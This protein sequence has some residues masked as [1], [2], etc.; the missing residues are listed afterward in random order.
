[1]PHTVFVRGIVV[2]VVGTGDLSVGRSHFVLA[3]TLSTIVAIFVQH[4]SVVAGAQIRANCILAL[5]LT[6]AVVDCALVDVGEEDGG[7]ST[8]LYG[9]VRGELNPQ[10]IRFGRYHVGQ[11]RS[12]EQSMALQILIGDLRVDGQRVVVTFGLE[13]VASLQV[14]V[15]EIED[16]LVLG[17]CD[18]FP[19]AVLGQGIDFGEGR[20]SDCSIVC[21]N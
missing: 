20:R 2:G 13:E 12:A 1:M 9:A 3:A 7:E 8:L 18:D 6:P 4:V 19:N 17:W 14:K 16:D 10:H 5:V 15:C 21:V 11:L